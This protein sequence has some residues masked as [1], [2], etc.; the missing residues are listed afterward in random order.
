MTILRPRVASLIPGNVSESESS[1][2]VNTLPIVADLYP[3]IQLW[4]QAYDLAISC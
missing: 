2:D 4:I 1:V 3:I